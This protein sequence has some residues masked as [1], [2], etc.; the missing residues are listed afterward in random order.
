[1]ATEWVAK[2]TTVS[3]EMILPAVGGGYLDRQWGTN[4]WVLVGLVL[5]GTVGFWH[6]LKMTRPKRSKPLPSD[7]GDNKDKDSTSGTPRQ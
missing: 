4:Y 6:L 2:I 5:G 3:L 7:N 1:V